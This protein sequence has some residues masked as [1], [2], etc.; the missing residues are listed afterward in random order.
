MLYDMQTAILIV[1]GWDI[2]VFSFI[3]WIGEV[4]LLVGAR[5]DWLLLRSI[6]HGYMPYSK[7]PISSSVVHSGIPRITSV[8]VQQYITDFTLSSLGM[9]SKTGLP[10]GPSISRPARMA[11]SGFLETMTLL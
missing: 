10:R 2:S 4:L 6:P 1:E 3:E 11:T 9:E 5:V 8:T 7:N